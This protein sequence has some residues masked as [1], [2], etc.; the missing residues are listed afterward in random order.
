MVKGGIVITQWENLKFRRFSAFEMLSYPASTQA[1]DLNSCGLV[2]SV[3]W[4]LL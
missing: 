3:C 4:D 1:M 2:A